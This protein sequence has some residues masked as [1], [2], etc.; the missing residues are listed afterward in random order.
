MNVDEAALYVDYLIDGDVK[1]TL[2]GV[3]FNFSF[4]GS[5]GDRYMDM[6]TGKL[7]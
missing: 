7:P 2:L 5:G 3:E 1:E 6:G 4:L